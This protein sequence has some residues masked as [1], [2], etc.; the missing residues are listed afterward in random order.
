MVAFHGMIHSM[1]SLKFSFRTFGIPSNKHG[2]ALGRCV[3]PF[4][5][6]FSIGESGVGQWNLQVVSKIP[7][8]SIMYLQ[9]C[10]G[11]RLCIPCMLIRQP[12]VLPS[13]RIG[14]SRS[15][16]HSRYTVWKETNDDGAVAVV[17][18]SW[19][20]LRK[21]RTDGCEWRLLLQVKQMWLRM[22]GVYHLILVVDDQIPYFKKVRR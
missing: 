3:L 15:S 18:S 20:N 14:I 4:F 1:Q 17:S 11:I 9:I 22:G 16:K 21:Q 13:L 12:P 7:I 6:F 8:A 10:A 5:H 2:P 19:R